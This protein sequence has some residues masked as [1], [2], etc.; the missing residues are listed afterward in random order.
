MSRDP[1]AVVQSHCSLTCSL[2]RK[3]PQTMP[4]WHLR[5]QLHMDETKVRQGSFGHH[6]WTFSALFFIHSG[7]L[8]MILLD[9]L[10][11][12]PPLGHGMYCRSLEDRQRHKAQVLPLPLSWMVSPEHLQRSP[13]PPCV[14]CVCKVGAS[15]NVAIPKVVLPFLTFPFY[16]FSLS[17]WYRSSNFLSETTEHNICFLAW[18]LTIAYFIE[19]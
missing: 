15:L 10:I 13:S 4:L 6:G 18:V 1:E 16:Y 9:S 14:P 2:D 11:C 8:V 12:R 5:T 17:S 3:H 19:R 7:L